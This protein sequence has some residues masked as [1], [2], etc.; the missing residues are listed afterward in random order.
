MKFAPLHKLTTER[1][2]LKKIEKSDSE[3]L[4]FLRSDKTI[5]Q[6]IKREKTESKE[7]ILTFIK[8]INNGIINNNWLYW[9]IS[10]KDNPTMIGTI[11]LWNFSAN[12]KV[13]EVGY[14]LMPKY[15]KKGIANEAL[16]RIIEFGFNTLNLESIEASTHKEN[17][18]SRSLLLKN[19]FRLIDNKKKDSDSINNILFALRNPIVKNDIE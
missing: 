11:C 8:K 3:T 14:E 13:A 19:K 16:N 6:F 5:N 12:S 17:K 1:L 9:C 7:E 15:Q 10:L 2:V 18:S 4:L